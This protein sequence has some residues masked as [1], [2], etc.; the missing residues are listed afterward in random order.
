MTATDW[1]KSSPEPSR[2]DHVSP[3]VY[4]RN[5][6]H[7]PPSANTGVQLVEHCVHILVP[8]RVIQQRATLVKDHLS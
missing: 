6:L 1:R 5:L 7:A 2:Q 8:S 3:A 4:W